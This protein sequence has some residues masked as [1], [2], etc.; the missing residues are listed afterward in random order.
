MPAARPTIRRIVGVDPGLA[1]AGW[2]VIETAGSKI[3]HI[4]H[5]SIQ[6]PA[7]KPRSERLLT[8]YTIFKNVLLE[9]LPRE[10][11]METLYFARNISSAMPVAEARGVLCLALA[12]QGIEVREY[13][14]MAIKQTVVGSGAANKAQVQE[15]IRIIL[16][17]AEIPKPD[18]AA[19]A[20]GAAVCRA[21]DILPLRVQR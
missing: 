2:G 8:I 6:T 20:L 3:I 5:G 10:A 12:E 16:G 1:S 19:D 9:Y 18:H 21:H 17:L 13:T 4:A 7:G 15:L 11:G 14:P